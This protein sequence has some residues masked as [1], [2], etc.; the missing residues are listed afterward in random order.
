MANN[1]PITDSPSTGLVPVPIRARIDGWTPDR[2]REFIE[3]L[4]DCGIIREAA[5]RVGMSERG[6]A[7]LR[8]RD[9]ANAFRTACDRALRLGAARLRTVAF[10]RA[11]EGTIKRH[12]Y[13]GELRAEERVFD[14][15]LLIYLLG[16]VG[17]LFPAAAS[18]Q[19]IERDWQDGLDALDGPPEPEPNWTG[20]EIWQTG[21]EWWTGFPPPAG[22]EGIELGEPEDR[23]YRRTL[24]PAEAEAV[25]RDMALDAEDR[26][27]AQQRKRDLFF[28]FEGDDFPPMEA[29]P[30]R[31]S[32]PFV[33]GDSEPK[34]AMDPP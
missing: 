2:Q 19:A 18:E 34:S 15:R 14:T 31:P 13:H 32:D 26:V 20:D 29:R 3:A 33:P 7:R 11:I 5:A 30:S 22:F 12:Y 24:S 1:H 28:G 23:D 21:G 8:R 25:D 16:K 10:E 6:V 17:G 27:A 4:A 9:D